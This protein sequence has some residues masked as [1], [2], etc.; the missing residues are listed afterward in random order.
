MTYLNVQDI[1]G[2]FVTLLNDFEKNGSPADTNLVILAASFLADDDHIFGEVNRAYIDSEIAWYNMQSTNIYDLPVEI[3]PKAWINTANE[4]GEINSNYGY[5]IYGDRSYC[6]FN[7]VVRELVNNPSSRR[8]QM[9]YTRP[10]IWIEYYENGKNDFICTNAVSYYINDGRLDCV[11]QMR[12]ND[13]WAGYRNDYAWQLH[14]QKRLAA[15]LIYHGISI[16]EM[17]ESLVGDIHWQVM[18]LHVYPSQFYLVD[19][20]RKTGLTTITKKE[21]NQL[22]PNSQYGIK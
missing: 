3:I 18:N 17:P 1:R 2:R 20:Y 10:S 4:H 19:H 16:P 7:Q 8:A 12:S 22:Y 5:L 14:V 13:C 6:Q 11:V 15:E 21:Y 9:I